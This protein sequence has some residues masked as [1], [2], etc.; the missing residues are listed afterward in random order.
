[1]EKDWK[2]AD[3]VKAKKR[4]IWILFLI[5][6][7]GAA[8]ILGAFYYLSVTVDR[9]GW[10][11]RG[12][13]YFYLDEKGKPISGWLEDEGT[14]YYFG[15]D[16]AMV[17]GWQEIDGQQYLFSQ[18]GAMR[19]GWVE[20]DDCFWYLREDGTPASGWQSVDGERRY[21]LEGGK[22]ATGWQMIDGSRCYLTNGGTMYTGWLYT[23]EGTYHL[24]NSG[25]LST[26]LTVV[27]GVT[28]YFFEGSGLELQGWLDIDSDRYYFGMDGAMV[29]GWQY[30]DGSRYFFDEDG[31]MHTGWL[32]DEEYRYYML[33][34]GSAAASPMVID[35]EQCFFTPEG[36]YV[37]L[38]N[39]R[40]GLPKNYNPEL[41]RYGEWSRVAAVAE[42]HLRQ[43]ILDCRATGVE[44]WL[45]CGYRT[46]TEQETILEERTQE[47][48]EKRKMGRTEAKLEALKTVAVPGYSEHQTG[49]A[50][51]IVC[52][53]DPV[54]LHE[55]CW[56]Y[57][58]I[59]RYPENK[60]HI[61]N[62]SYEHWHYRYVGTRVSMAMKD[63]GLCLE[64][65]LGAA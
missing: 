28:Y 43:M 46:Q 5:A 58:F 27:D 32:Q 36:I 12:G 60:S 3:C 17:T 56:E 47:Y 7:L 14:R 13:Q 29:T 22:L 45:N 53:V 20:M 16:N 63:T 8:A 55:H 4:A 49:L 19:T 24:N 65:Y 18:A 34:D 44:C 51:D 61:T 9:S 33:E 2:R 11:E 1:M 26:G 64:E 39:Y 62:I 37:M 57:G 35:G 30:I 6:L 48:I 40:Y 59:L 25:H 10:M 50:M 23:D 31:T 21:F 52:S 54:W 15:I 38:V 41:V 42:N